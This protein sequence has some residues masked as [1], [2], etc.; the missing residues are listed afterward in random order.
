[1]KRIVLFTCAAVLTAACG[2]K[3]SWEADLHERLLTDFNKSEAEIKEYIARYI[4]DVS[5]GMLRSWEDAKAL[6]YM[7][8]DGEKRYFRNAGP[9]LFRVDPRCAAIKDSVDALNSTPDKGSLSGTSIVG[10]AAIDAV[11]DPA[12]IAEVRSGG[13]ASPL[14]QP[15]HARMTFTLTVEADAVPAGETIRCWLPYPR[16]DLPYQTG[17]RLIGTSED[18][19]VL[20]QEHQE[21]CVHSTL[22]MERKAVAGEPTVFSEQFELTTWGRY[23]DLSPQKVQPYQGGMDSGEYAFYTGEQAPHTVFSPRLRALADSL[24]AGIDNPY[25]QVRAIYTWIDKIPWASAREYSTL[26]NIP[27]YV[28]DNGHGDCGQVTL[29]LIA[30]CRIKGIPAEFESGLMTHSQDTWNLHDWARVY[31]EGV[32]W[33]PVDQSFGI[34]S[35]TMPADGGTGGLSQE[36]ER[37]TPTYAEGEDPCT[38]FYLGGLD[39][40]RLYVNKGW[41][42][43]L[44]P[45]KAYPRSETVDFQRGEVEWRGGNLYFPKW[46]YHL[47]IEE[48][49]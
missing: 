15:F 13:G 23:F 10:H 9:N 33:V 4:P 14:A 20:S 21:D 24:T 11:N 29:L 3:Y 28:L 30:L 43:K 42:G 2:P 48:L 16:T 49:D 26:S 35:F 27:E 47:D 38:Y 8:I 40:H 7:V 31:F 6:E 32:G 39:S 1:M 19:Y 17:V 36:A 44:Y 46:D 34:Q 22:Y 12:I 37:A 25:G 5:D 18:E 41:G 45:E